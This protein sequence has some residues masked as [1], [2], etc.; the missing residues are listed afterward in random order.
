MISIHH[1][2]TAA[3]Y[4]L[5]GAVL[6]GGMLMAAGGCAPQAQIVP[7][8]PP[9][10]FQPHSSEF[11]GLAAGV[12]P[13]S[14]RRT[15]DIGF[16]ADGRPLAVEVFG[17]GPRTVLVLGGIHGDET[18]SV[19]VARFLA[20]Y[21]A[22]NSE[23][24]AGKTVAV[25]VNANPTGAANR[26][27]TN[28]RGVDLN[29]NFPASNWRPGTLGRRDFPGPAP[30]SEPETQAILRATELLR[31]A[32]IIS[33]HTAAREG[34]CN[35]FDGPAEGLARLMAA[36]NGYPVLANIGHPTPGSLGSWAGIDRGI[37][38][39]TLE[40]PEN[41]PAAECW[42]RNRGALLDV[43]SADVP[44]PEAVVRPL[45]GGRSLTDRVPDPL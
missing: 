34:T 30:A 16:A 28:A 20:D 22:A 43:I 31:P 13:A 33:L 25:L 35:N 17:S 40:L 6:I 19:E 2:K 36:Q 27:R 44:A 38:V 10:D 21:L 14:S 39:L 29:R 1:A 24:L 45:Q 11:H 15:L 41:R 3:A 5:A 18:R 8:I 7:S 37:A 9:A 23:A 26:T 12:A 4:R 32:C 42:Q